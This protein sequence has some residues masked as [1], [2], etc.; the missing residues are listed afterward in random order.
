MLTISRGKRLWIVDETGLAQP[1]RSHKDIT[2]KAR[3][4]NL[5]DWWVEEK[6]PDWTPPPPT[7]LLSLAAANVGH[8][9]AAPSGGAGMKTGAGHKPQPYDD[10]GRYTGPGGGQAR[11]SKT[12]QSGHEPLNEVLIADRDRIKSDAGGL[13]GGPEVRGPVTKPE[14][15]VTWK[16]DDTNKLNPNLDEL[17]PQM[18]ETIERMRTG[19]QELESFNINSGNRVPLTELDPHADGRAVDVNRI[20]DLPV[21]DLKTAQVEAAEQARRAADNLEN[22]TR[23]QPEVNQVIG[24][25][26]GWEYKEGKKTDILRTDPRT[27][28]HHNHYH[29]NVWRRVPSRPLQ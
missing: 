21:K 11:S 1:V 22:W 26:G 8:V 5:P 16:N 19:I 23:D 27:R 18:R 17:K 15:A 4:G 29:I 28:E 24:P 13:S 10:H 6:D 25:N 7:S 12:G 2:G 3:G 14:A 20:N 9:E